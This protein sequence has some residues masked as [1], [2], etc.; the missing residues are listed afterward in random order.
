MYGCRFVKRINVVSGHD[1]CQTVVKFS[2]IL[3]IT[4]DLT[5]FHIHKHYLDI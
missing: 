5:N 2:N 3:D 4:H 1:V